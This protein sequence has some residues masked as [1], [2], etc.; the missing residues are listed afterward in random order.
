[1][2]DATS[3]RTVDHPS[4]G[5]AL[6]LQEDATSR[7]TVD[8]PPSGGAQPLQEDATSRSVV[9]RRPCGGSPSFPGFAAAP[10][11]N[12][13]QQLALEEGPE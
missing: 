7:R 2:E 6:P 8:H 10:G 4:S 3:R 13:Q 9:D 5:G 12:F 11:S 1:M